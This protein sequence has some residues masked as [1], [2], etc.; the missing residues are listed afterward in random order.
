MRVL[1]LLILFLWHNI[2]LFLTVRNDDVAADEEDETPSSITTTPARTDITPARPRPIAPL[3]S[4]PASR[5]ERKSGQG[6]TKRP[7]SLASNTTSELHEMLRES[8]EHMKSYLKMTNDLV[9][10]ERKKTA[11]L[12]EIKD[13]LLSLLQPGDGRPRKRTQNPSPRK[14]RPRTE[15]SSNDSESGQ[16]SS[17]EFE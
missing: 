14:K 11:I 16:S 2:L 10:E 9:R 6:N 15:V 17:E 8:S 4:G 13:G 3:I 1:F 7:N 5:T 12:S